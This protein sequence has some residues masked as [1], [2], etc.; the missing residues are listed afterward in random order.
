M[1]KYWLIR[2]QANKILG[3]VAKSKVLELLDKKALNDEDE[4]SSGNGHWFWIKEK[5]FVE[6]YLYG[7]ESQPFNPISEAKSVLSKD[8]SHTTQEKGHQ[9]HIESHVEDTLFLSKKQVGSK[10][11]TKE[12]EKRKDEEDSQDQDN[13]DNI[14]NQSKPTND[15]TKD[16]P[17][18][19]RYRIL[20]ISI[21]LLVILAIAIYFLWPLLGYKI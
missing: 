15:S 20:S 7:D 10:N 5:D 4:V 12:L 8:S 2:T 19:E 13:S 14:V 18:K 1:S 11:D 17:M 9:Q 3:P 21:I 6:K 16:N